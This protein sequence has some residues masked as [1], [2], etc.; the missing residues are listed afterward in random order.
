[1]IDSIEKNMEYVVD[2]VAD[3]KE[4]L[5]EAVVYKKSATKVNIVLRLYLQTL[6]FFCQITEQNRLNTRD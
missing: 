4:V 6:L 2:Y 5:V 3:A 1:M